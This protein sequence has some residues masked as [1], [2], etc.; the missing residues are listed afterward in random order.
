M[1]FTGAPAG[2]GKGD[3]PLGNVVKCFVH[4]QLQSNAEIFTIF[5][6]SEW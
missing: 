4:E 5:G 1:I 6:D 2:M 3:L